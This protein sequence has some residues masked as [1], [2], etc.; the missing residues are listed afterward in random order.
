MTTEL[1]VENGLVFTNEGFKKAALK[2]KE[3]RIDGLFDVND[4]PAIGVEAD[5]IDAE[6]CLI[7]PGFIDAH[8]HFN[9]PGRTDW[10]GMETGSLAAAAGGTTTIFDMPL[11]CAP[12]I[13]NSERLRNKQEY[14]TGKS[15][16]DYGLWGGLTADNLGN[17]K[18]LEEMAEAII[19]WKAFMSESGIDDFR[20]LSPQD[21][22]QAMMLAKEHHKIL[23]LHAEWEEEVQKLAG[24]YKNKRG[25]N[26][27]MAYL[28]SRP[29]SAEEK[30]V[31]HALE[32]AAKYGT[33]VHFVHIS[34]ARN[35]ERI[36]E[37]KKSGVHVTV[38]T[39]PHYLVFNDQDFIKNGAVFKCA[40]PL[41]PQNE[42]EGLWDCIARGWIDTIGSDH[43]PCLYSMKSAA[44]IWDVWGGIQ[45]VQFTWLA[46]LDEALKRGISLEKVLP[47]GSAFAADRFGISD[48]KGRIMPGLDADL[49]LLRL[50]ESTIADKAS[51]KFRNA[52]SPYEN[53]VFQLRVKKTI[54]R[55]KV[56]YD[57]VS[58]ISGKKYGRCLTVGKERISG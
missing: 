48:K 22:E 28:A 35:V 7:V 23:A 33:G 25:M 36:Q 26:E 14:L 1:W 37:A 31:N 30:A 16:V 56:I 21:L 4:H 46:L 57:D 44:S 9:D 43:S 8:V 12:S 13:I 32:L 24:L 49:V 34:S 51:F 11:N 6:G 17:K 2:M 29:V 38:E 3:G 47:L 42:V 39:C 53:K 5:T 10:E 55:G 27:R 40:P 52:Y 50:D 58:G 15:Y 19:G 54:L 41:R 18:E 45:G 20:Y